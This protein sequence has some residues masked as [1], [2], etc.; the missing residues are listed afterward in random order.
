MASISSRQFA[1]LA[2]ISARKAG[3]ALARIARRDNE[4]WRDAHLAVRMIAGR[5]GRSGLQ[6]EVE[7]DSLP[8]GLKE[9]FKASSNLP[10]AALPATSSAAKRTLYLAV[11]NKPLS[12]KKGSR[13]RAQA[14]RAL[15]TMPI[16]DPETGALKTFGAR[17]LQRLVASYDVHGVAGLGRKR[18]ADAGGD[19]VV[20]SRKWDRAAASLPRETKVAI[21]AEVVAYIRAQ[22]KNHESVGNIAFKARQKLGGLS[23]E[24]GVEPPPGACDIP[25]AMIE[26]ETAYRK[27]AQRRLDAKAFADD[28]PG[29]RRTREGA[30]PMEVVFG[31][32]HPIDVLLCEFDGL[33]RYA[34]GISWWDMATNRV[35]MSV[36]VL[37]KGQG[38][39]N[40]HVIDSFI[41]MALAWGL[42][43]TLYID[44]GSEYNFAEF[45]EDALLLASN[46]GQRVIVKA[47]PY[48]ARAKPIEGVFISAT[49]PVQ[50]ANGNDTVV[51]N[52][53]AGTGP[54]WFLL[55]TKQVFR[56]LIWQKRI[57]YEFQAL[58][59]S[60]ESEVFTR[61]QYLYGVRA[62]VNAGFGLWQTAFGSQ[63]PLTAANYAAARQAMM[64]LRGDRGGILGVMPNVLVVPPSLEPNARTLLKATSVAELVG[65]TGPLMEAIAGPGLAVPITNVWYES[66]DLIVTPY[67]A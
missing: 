36:L 26:A 5:G 66:A 54:A 53:Q 42:P 23:R 7:V 47:I 6:Y 49:H 37:P 48:N 60:N 34:V 18:R 52:M 25:R 24:H 30:R 8:D 2:G 13:E 65:S 57:P 20:V 50:D 64:S 67:L 35:W 56:P 19:R 39:R 43:G 40:E 21:R 27:A 32:V 61:D 46:T 38:V 44:N 16:L 11:L 1:E 63:A 9:R 58:V 29:I 28:L 55:S 14:I 51:S 45:I 4:A 15:A 17:S 10:V 41:E 31:D 3:A 12:H 62:R 33:Q 22:H 59:S